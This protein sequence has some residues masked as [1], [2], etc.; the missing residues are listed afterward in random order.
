MS[1]N[2]PR[3]VL[4]WVQSLDLS[5][6]MKHPRRDFSN[7]FLVAEI[8]SKYWKGVPMHSIDNGTAIP[9]KRDNWTTIEKLLAAK[10]F[11]LT[12]ELVG[13]VILSKEGAAVQLVCGL[14]THLTNRKIQI[15]PPISADEQKVPAFRRPNAATL[16]R[17]LQSKEVVEQAL[18]E[19]DLKKK[20][21]KA[22]D[23]LR[24][25]A[26]AQQR[27]KVED[28]TRFKSKPLRRMTAMKPPDTAKPDGPAVNFKEV[29]LKTVDSDLALRTHHRADGGGGGTPSTLSGGSPV[30][31]ESD[32]ESL[33]AVAS[34]EVHAI[35]A[36][37]DVRPTFAEGAAH[38]YFAWFCAHLREIEGETAEG[39]GDTKQLVWDALISR[40]EAMARS[41]YSR[42]HELGKMAA[43]MSALLEAGVRGSGVE[44]PPAHDADQG[45]M[46]LSV[47]GSEVTKIDSGASWDACQRHLLPACA[48]ALTR[49]SPSVRQ[50]VVAMFCAWFRPYKATE[51]LRALHTLRHACVDA[52]GVPD[53]AGFLQAV[54]LLANVEQA[55]VAGNADVSAYVRN[56]AMEGLTLC[57]PRGRAAALHV[58]AALSTG[59]GSLPDRCVD[60]AV[61]LAESAADSPE[62]REVQAAL[63]S[64]AA[65]LF[66][67]ADE[68]NSPARRNAAERVAS[69]L[70]VPRTHPDVK[71][72]ALSVLGRHL[73]CS[74]SALCVRYLGVLVG[75]SDKDF[76]REVGA[77]A[78]SDVVSSS[79]TTG[80][81]VLTAAMDWQA[82][83]VG[84]YAAEL[85]AKAKQNAAGQERYLRLLAAALRSNAAEAESEEA[86]VVS[87]FTPPLTSRFVRV[88]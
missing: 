17:E 62:H 37:S 2:L 36:A 8:L 40:A 29:R 81:T 55:S 18:G 52:R 74:G 38:N 51:T 33:S 48:S 20:E 10:G 26:Q 9:K 47:V 3:E 4:K 76:E 14:Y 71:R 82:A 12:K 80:Y 50:A 72:V 86:I 5:Y 46:L 30:G 1:A 75:L 34:R 41:V 6:S 87:L 60:A 53:D 56:R 43:S 13:G 78:A 83:A 22:Q 15:L 28:P 66:D 59:G 31:G 19:Q 25:L 58:L 16:M 61:Q 64:F 85:F 32:G 69:A 88:M 39:G 27:E 65:A 11:T 45:M 73:T 35:L 24:D 44:A 42:P 67:A 23:T 49:G 54:M 77:E 63:A 84:L 68:G 57:D 21:A 79:V 7:G 70:L